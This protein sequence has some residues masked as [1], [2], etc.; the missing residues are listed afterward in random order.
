DYLCAQIREV[1]ALHPTC[2]GIF[3]DI[4]SGGDC[5]CKW[6]MEWMAKRGL[7][8]SKPEDREIAAEHTLQKYFERT[9][10]ACRVKDKAMRV[11]HNAGHVTPGQRGILPFFSHLELESLPTGGWG[12]DHFP[13]SAKYAAGLGMDYLG[14]TGKFHFSWGEFGGFKHPN[15]L[16]YECAAMLAHGSKCSVGD[17]LH[18]CGKMDPSTYAL[19]GEAYAEVEQKEAWCCGVKGVAD[20]GLLLSGSVNK[21]GW[22]HRHDDT[23][24]A[25]ALLEG[26]VLFDVLDTE[27]DFAKYRVLIIP[28][29]VVI[30]APLK[31]KLDRHLAKGGK[32]FLCGQSGLAEDNKTFLFD[33]GA[34]CEGV[35]PFSPDYIVPRKDL[36]APYVDTPLVAY[37]ASRRVRVTDGVSL[38]DVYDP[39]FNRTFARFC[40]HR[41]TPNET[42]PSGFACGVMKGNVMYLA[43]PVFSHY[44]DHGMTAHREFI[45]RA[46]RLLLGETSLEVRGLPS[47]GRVTLMEQP[48]N[49]RYVAHLLHANTILRGAW[50]GADSSARQ[51]EV[52]EDLTPL[53]DVGVSVKV[54]RKIKGVRLVP[55]N[56]PLD[57][58]AKDGVVS[59]TVPRLLCHQMV[60]LAW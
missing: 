9:T 18:P 20:V 36:R 25:R 41:H 2:H 58:T 46:L 59:F 13:V 29:T 60:E 31:K 52:I 56:T 38:G 40:S 45:V 23:G 11:F 24:A 22:G 47:T 35:S 8:A 32:L 54:P 1:V 49:K 57:F 33:C 5:C 50:N 16:R 4:I 7:D 28:D 17:Q 42:K 34:E 48:A 10:A 39:Y 55:E 51:V 6:C 12:Y 26:H 15:A 44:N 27:S 3:L 21:G 14:M 19:I 53:H 43:H 30:D 37:Y